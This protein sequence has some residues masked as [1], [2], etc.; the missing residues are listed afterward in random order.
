MAL[1]PKHQVFVDE[2]IRT[3]NA[4]DAYCAAYPKSSR[5]AARTHGA[6][7][8]ANGNIA[9]EI[10]TRIAERAMGSA[11]VLDRLGQM[12]RGDMSDFWEIPE[13]GQPF[14]N[15]TSQRA[16]DKLHLIR[17][18]KVKTTTRMVGEIE[19]VTTETDFEP[20]DAQ[21]ALVHIGKHHKLFT[22]KVEHD[23]SKEASDTAAALIAAMK[24]GATFQKR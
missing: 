1:T 11:E 22:D 13:H 2:Y 24:Q 12:A 20:Y 14:L 6:R 9:E 7:L 19:V 18:L 4:T 21:S 23:L 5:E 8:V 10:A 15:L 16:K 3:W 17:K